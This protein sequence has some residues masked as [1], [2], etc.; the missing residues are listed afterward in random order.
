MQMISY[1]NQ[2]FWNTFSD[3]CGDREPCDELAVEFI[4]HIYGE[5]EDESREIRA[6]ILLGVLQ[7]Q[8]AM[9][10]PTMPGN[11]TRH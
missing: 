4:G 3:F 5:P 7:T 11:M 8:L 9:R 1:S 6:S 2:D 10:S